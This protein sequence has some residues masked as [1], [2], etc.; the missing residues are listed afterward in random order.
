[1][2]LFFQSE[3]IMNKIL[4]MEIIIIKKIFLKIKWVIK[5]KLY[6]VLCRLI[7]KGIILILKS[8]NNLIFEYK[9]Y[10]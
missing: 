6:L 9:L 10:I 4:K 8:N 7:K 3:I 2:Y 1:M 5:T